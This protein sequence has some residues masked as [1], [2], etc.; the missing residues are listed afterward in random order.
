MTFVRRKEKKAIAS[1][2][3]LYASRS[4]YPRRMGKVNTSQVAD[5][6]Q[7]K[8]QSHIPVLMLNADVIK[9]ILAAAVLLTCVGCADSIFRT[10]PLND[11]PSLFVGLASFEDPEKLTSIHHNHPMEWSDGDLRM[12]LAGV[13]VQKRG[14]IMDPSKPPEAVFSSDDII[15][16]TPALREAF[17]VARPSDWIVFALWGSS[18][19]TEALEV[20]SGGMFLQ[21]QRLHMILANHREQVSSEREGIKGIRSNP[22]RSMRDLTKGKL[23]FDPARYMI[24]SRDNRMAGGHD[25]PASELILDFKALLASNRL[26]TPTDQRK[27]TVPDSSPTG[28]PP[29]TESEVGKLKEEIS[30]LKEELSRLQHQITQQ[31]EELFRQ[32]TPQSHQPS[33]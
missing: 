21:D 28:S 20:T 19:K 33:P 32:K 2:L 3:T 6:H 29:S 8:L 24:D 12:I 31:A 27:L 7:S 22:L 26:S 11:E 25:S 14:G 13:Y 5:N 9:A 10:Q 23:I 17:K 30:N 15:L 16:L 1:R 18:P 4:Y